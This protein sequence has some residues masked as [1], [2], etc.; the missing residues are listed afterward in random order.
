MIAE[1]IIIGALSTVGLLI[2]LYFTLVQRG[3]ISAETRFVPRFC[4]IGK[5]TCLTLLSTQEARLFKIPN[6]HLGILYY[7]TI[8][9][10]A[11]VSDLWQQFHTLLVLAS[12]ATVGMGMYL[13]Y[14]LLVRLRL[15]CILCF[16]SHSINLFIFLVLLAA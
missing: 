7:M 2:S 5:D 6:F 3:T 4:R 8:I 16:I 13:S 15:S 11:C 9:T 10:L 14:A 12:L 1:Q